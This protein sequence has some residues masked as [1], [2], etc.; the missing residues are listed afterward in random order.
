[1]S[2]WT[3]EAS[4]GAIA[5]GRLPEEA[6]AAC[7]A[8]GAALRRRVWDPI[9][10]HLDGTDHVVV[11][12]DAALHL[13]TFSALPDGAAAYLAETG[14]L[15][16][17]LSS[18]R[19]LVARASTA[20]RGAGLLAVGGPAYDETSL[21]A[22][23][24]PTGERPA[25]GSLAAGATD[26]GRGARSTCGD[27]RSIRFE[28]LPGSAREAREVV[29]LFRKGRGAGRGQE[30]RTAGH[31][32]PEGRREAG[33]SLLLGPAASEAAFKQQAPGRR[34]LHLAT[35]G[36]FLTG[37]CPSALSSSRGIGGLAPAEGESQRTAAAGESPLLLSGLALAGANHRAFAGAEEEDGVLTAGEI[38]AMD[39]S[40]IEWV[41]LSACDTGVGEIEA[42]EGVLGL[43]RAFQVAG[44]GTLIMSL[45]AVEDDTARRWMGELYEGRLLKGLPTAEAARGAELELLRHRRRNKQSTHPFYWAG[46]VAAGDWR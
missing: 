4:R 39:L 14:P 43:R 19:D 18:E 1:V 12:P 16:H 40:G 9:A 21:F 5:G 27:F 38:A 35:H 42:G 2:R 26:P 45:W 3:E 34:I 37:R 32:G 11:V 24:T 13:V 46:F 6:E 36:F 22:G 23:L 30:S 15:F 8:A 41:V 20:S 33:A 7:R 29:T 44:A 31:G 28:P 17:Y 25:A 10:A